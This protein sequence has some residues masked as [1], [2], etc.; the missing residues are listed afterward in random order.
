MTSEID[1]RG[2]YVLRHHTLVT[3][4]FLQVDQ[5]RAEEFNH[6]NA[7]WGLDISDI[8]DRQLENIK[9]QVRFSSSYGL[10]LAFVCKAVRVVAAEACTPVE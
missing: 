3:L 2:F 5:F 10:D 4:R 1:P 6:Q 8:S 9:F 7:L